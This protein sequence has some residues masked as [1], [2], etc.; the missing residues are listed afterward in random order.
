[1]VGMAGDWRAFFI[2]VLIAYLAGK[3]ISA[4]KRKNPQIQAVPIT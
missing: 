2:I 1:M 4:Q 3:N